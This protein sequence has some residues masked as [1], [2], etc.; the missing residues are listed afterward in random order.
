MCSSCIFTSVIL[1]LLYQASRVVISATT[2]IRVYHTWLLAVVFEASNF[3]LQGHSFSRSSGAGDPFRWFFM[4]SVTESYNTGASV[5]RPP[6][7]G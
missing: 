3:L 1:S 6:Q 4:V 7:R 5:N 2:S